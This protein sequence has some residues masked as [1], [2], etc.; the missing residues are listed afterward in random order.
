MV[1][2]SSIILGALFG[3]M[4]G[5][6]AVLGLGSFGMAAL[7]FGIDLAVSYGISS[8]LIKNP[9][10]G[11]VSPQGTEIQLGPATDNKM[12]VVYGHRYAKPIVTDA[13]ISTDQQTMWYVLPFSEKNSG[14]TNFG[15][16]YYDGKLLIFDPANPNSITGWYTQPKRH[17]KNGG[18]YNTKAAGKLEMYFYKNGSLI[19]GTT[20][21]AYD[22][23]DNGGGNFDIGTQHIVSTNETAI[24]V[25]QN[26]AIPATTRWT[27]ATTM[28]GSTFAVIKLT[29]D[30]A[31]GIYG[32]GGMD[33]EIINSLSSPGDVILDYF[34]NTT[35]GCGIALSSINT[36]T[37]AT[38]NYYSNQPLSIY[39]TDN[40][41][42]STSTTYQI[43]GIL[44]TTQDCLTNLNNLTDACDS[45]VN[46]DER[47]GQWGVRMNISLEQTGG[48]TATM[49]VI[50]S[51]QIIGGI[52]LT[53]TD[54]KTSANA[55]SVAFPNSDI[56]NQTDYRYYFL[57]EDRP[58][59]IS[60]NEPDNRIDINMPFVTDAIQATYLGYRKLYMSREDIVVN[61][62]MDYSGIGINAGDIVAVN[63]EWYGWTQGQYNNGYYPG[64]PFRVTQ[65]K[66]AKDSNSGFL[67]VQITAMAYNDSIYTTMNP[68]YYT[69]DTFG[70][71]I[72]AGNVTQPGQPFTP[73]SS[74][75]PTP[76]YP[77]SSVPLFVIS[78]ETPANGVI[79]E[80][81]L[82]YGING[83]PG[84]DTSW[85]LL[86]RTN[87]N[88]NTIPN[89][90]SGSPNYVNFAITGL[91]AG[92]YYFAT[93]CT[94]LNGFSAF[95]PVSSPVFSWAPATQAGTAVDSTNANNVQMNAGSGE[96]YLTHAP[97]ST[98]YSAQYANNNLKFNATSNTLI[99][100]SI[101]LSST[102]LLA[103]LNSAPSSPSA[104]T[105]A[106]AHGTWGGATTSTNYLTYYNGV[107]WRPI[108]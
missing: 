22:M 17:S 81:E 25:L 53:P 6:A 90:P 23:I 5:A 15:N 43:N 58:E 56:I 64:K 79:T 97:N 107:A 84:T 55:I 29:Y 13:I 37:L 78:S 102:A 51:N 95:S 35:Y 104:G 93:R 30:Q 91:S 7:S 98:G 26:T 70:M 39:D 3:D 103:P 21:Y 24:S 4:I 12:P 8:L 45:W 106:M 47:L 42:V 34:T 54:L 40:N 16:V 74:T 38:L 94:G 2:P 27:T 44:D 82:W 63:H 87:G 105:I 33:A 52:N 72:D 32:L 9:G 50:T 99:S 60:P 65:I 57:K 80:M 85:V 68:H 89:S 88:G 77:S 69:P 92:N 62:S 36:A 100:P 20:H 73:A 14:D 75:T 18:Q 28:H 46:W 1:M 31:G 76:Q 49:R 71:A 48:S 19:T 96:Y 10:S 61:F 41:L 86:Q 67:G 59:L 83:S 101:S 66:E 108:V 11:Q